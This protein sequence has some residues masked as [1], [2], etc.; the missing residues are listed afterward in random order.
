M[1]FARQVRDAIVAPR[2]RALMSALA[3]G[4]HGGELADIGHRYWA[5]RLAAVR[6]LVERAVAAGELPADVD[7]DAFV[8]RVVGPIRFSVFGPGSAVDDAFVEQCVEVALAGTA[9]VST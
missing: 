9:R 6:P 3:A 5:G 7:P 1:E 2:S 8:V 4:G